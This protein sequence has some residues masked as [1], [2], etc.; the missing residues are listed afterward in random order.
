MSQKCLVSH[1]ALPLLSTVGSFGYDLQR[2]LCIATNSKLH[3]ESIHFMLFEVVKLDET[4]LANFAMS[5]SYVISI[6]P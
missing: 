6:S 2:F 5:F 3:Q 4:Q 1:L